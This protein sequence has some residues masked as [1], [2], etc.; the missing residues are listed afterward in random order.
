MSL[1]M[2]RRGYSGTKSRVASTVTLLFAS[3]ATLI[4][5]IVFLVDVSFVAIVR[6][7]VKDETHDLQ[8]NWGNAVRRF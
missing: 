5:I 7:K 2:L 1:S 6:N 3:V 4:T 8:I